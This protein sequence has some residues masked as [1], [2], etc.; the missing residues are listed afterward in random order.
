MVKH[1]NIAI[2]VMV[3]VNLAISFLWH[4]PVIFGKIWLNALNQKYELPVPPLI[5]VIT[6][7]IAMNYFISWLIQVLNRY[8]F[9]GGI[10]TGLI[11]YFG[12]VLPIIICLYQL[13]NLPYAVLFLDLS[14]IGIIILL[15]FGVLSV[16][17]AKETTDTSG[18]DNK[19][20]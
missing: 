5:F 19:T 3:V 14:M 12:G 6:S 7:F 1:N 4:S 16:W 20:V 18:E 13:L 8:T 10:K 9:L 11:F 2:W 17:K 15:T